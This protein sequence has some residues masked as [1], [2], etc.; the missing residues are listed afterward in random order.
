LPINYYKSCIQWFLKN[1]SNPYFI[2]VKYI[3]WLLFFVMH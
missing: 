1:I 3:N 2:Y